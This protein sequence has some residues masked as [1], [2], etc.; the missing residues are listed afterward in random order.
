MRTRLLRGGNRHARPFAMRRARVFARPAW[1]RRCGFRMT[2]RAAL[3]NWRD[4][5]DLHWVICGGDEFVELEDFDVGRINV[6]FGRRPLVLGFASRTIALGRLDPFPVRQGMAAMCAK[7]PAG[8]DVERTSQ[9]SAGRS[10]LG[11]VRAYGVAMVKPASRTG[12]TF[13]I[14]EVRPAPYQLRNRAICPWRKAPRADDFRNLSKAIQSCFRHSGTLHAF[15]ETFSGGQV[16]AAGKT[17]QMRE[18]KVGIEGKAGP[19]CRLRLFLSLKR[20][21]GRRELEMRH[22]PVSIGVNGSLERS[23]RLLVSAEA[24]SRAAGKRP[25]VRKSEV[26]RT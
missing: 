23:G 2:S 26:A 13:R 9:I 8:V 6:E 21:E 11:G 12:A 5:D 18:A 14:F 10:L 20:C 19:S 15:E 17:S 16:G 25:P 1:R 3:S 7:R 22:W 24:K 4:H